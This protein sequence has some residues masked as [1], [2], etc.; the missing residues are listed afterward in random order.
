[1][2]SKIKINHCFELAYDKYSKV[3]YYLLLRK[4]F[5]IGS[6]QKFSKNVNIT[7]NAIETLNNIAINFK[8]VKNCFGF[9]KIQ[10][11][12]VRKIVTSIRLMR[13]LIR[14]VH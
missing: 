6:I 11:G 2:R 5:K 14:G 1:M 3:F 12:E 13:S 4:K 9:T 7:Y 10:K 8:N